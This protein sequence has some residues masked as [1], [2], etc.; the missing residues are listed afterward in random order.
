MSARHYSRTRHALRE[1]RGPPSCPPRRIVFPLILSPSSPP[2]LSLSF[3]LFLS[4]SPPLSFDFISSRIARWSRQRISR[5]D[6]GS[7]FVDAIRAGTRRGGCVSLGRNDR[8]TGRPNRF[9]RLNSFC[10]P[11]SRNAGRMRS[12]QEKWWGRER[13]EAGAFKRDRRLTGSPLRLRAIRID[14][15][16]HSWCIV[17]RPFAAFPIAM[18][19]Q[20]Q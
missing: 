20:S 10:I 2:S 3:S 11:R 1:R 17:S 6:G 16:L 19:N 18:I 12:A 7:P 15:V 4:L 5:R 9:A 8:I 13:V 14:R